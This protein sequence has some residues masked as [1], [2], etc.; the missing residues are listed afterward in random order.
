VKISIILIAIVLTFLPNGFNC[1]ES[2][3]GTVCDIDGNVYKTV[4]IGNQWWMAE[5]LRV[6]RNPKGQLIQSYFYNDD[7]SSYGKYGRLYTWDVAMDNISQ[8]NAQG[9]APGGWHIPS[10]LEWEELV[11]T[12]GGEY[13]VAEQILRTAMYIFMNMPCSGVLLLLMRNALITWESAMITNGI[14]SLPK[15]MAESTSDV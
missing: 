10:A 5:N 1:Q 11:K 9:I 4:K 15:K 2:G 6:T 12:L 3:S 8:E 14:S 7:Q 13:K